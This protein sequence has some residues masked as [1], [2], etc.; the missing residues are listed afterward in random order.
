MRTGVDLFLN[1]LVKKFYNSHKLP[2]PSGRLGDFASKNSLF[3]R[4]IKR[5]E[6]HK[7]TDSRTQT[8]GNKEGR[9]RNL[10]YFYSGF[11][12]GMPDFYVV[13]W[14]GEKILEWL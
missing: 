8:P 13:I 1:C 7:Q 3:G 5:E 11:R 4:E 9:A 14:T 12:K 10:L 2:N 6:K